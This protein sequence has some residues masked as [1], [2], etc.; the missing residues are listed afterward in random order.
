MNTP[1]PPPYNEF[2]NASAQNNT[3]SKW[4]AWYNKF[5]EINFNNNEAHQYATIFTNNEIELNMI[6]QLNEGTLKLM[7]ID[8]AGHRIRILGLQNKNL[9]PTATSMVQA[10]PTTVNVS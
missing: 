10:Q 6:N 8:K 5:L 9:Q 7:G 1:L 4:Q 3:N 2:N